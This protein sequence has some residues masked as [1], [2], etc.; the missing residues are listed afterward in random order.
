LAAPAIVTASLGG[1][2]T[3]LPT[4]GVF[5]DGMIMGFL[6]PVGSVNQTPRTLIL[7]G[8]TINSAVSASITGGPLALAY[9]LAFGST[10]LSLATAETAS[11]ATGTTKMP[12]R[13]A[14]GMECFPVTASIGTGPTGPGVNVTFPVPYVVNPGEYL[15]IIVKNVGVV[16]SAGS[17]TTFVGINGAWE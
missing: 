11:F 1:Q 13:V 17:I 6:N 4:L 3:Y 8:I 15:H 7:T 2:A 16:S 10:A 5:T 9:I 12:R 14:L